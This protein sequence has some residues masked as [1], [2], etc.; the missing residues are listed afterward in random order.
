[1]KAVIRAHSIKSLFDGER[2]DDMLISNMKVTPHRFLFSRFST[3]PP[4]RINDV[5]EAED[6][7]EEEVEPMHF[8]KVFDGIAVAPDE[9]KV[10]KTCRAFHVTFGDMSEHGYHGGRQCN[11]CR[12]RIME[13]I[14]V[15]GDSDLRVAH[16]TEQ[17]M[18]QQDAEFAILVKQRE[19]RDAAKIAS[20]IRSKRGAHKFVDVKMAMEFQKA[21]EKDG[22]RDRQCRIS[23]ALQKGF[24]S[25]SRSH[26]QMND[27]LVPMEFAGIQWPPHATIFAKEFELIPGW[28]LDLTTTDEPSCPQNKVSEA[29]ISCSKEGQSR[30]EASS[31]L[32]EQF[33]LAAVVRLCV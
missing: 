7:D 1:M 25:G 11:G 20:D 30:I 4:T 28:S 12:A 5:G 29:Y 15:D 33:A 6:E 23:V 21:L 3:K 16:Y 2:W 8:D 10:E 22:E 14:F 26:G 19:L 31:R 17:V 13:H 9:S 27:I 18:A 24:R 32:F